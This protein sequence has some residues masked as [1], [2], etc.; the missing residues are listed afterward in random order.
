MASSAPAGRGTAGGHSPAAA[1]CAAGAAVP[2]PPPPGCRSPAPGRLTAV[3]LSATP[4]LLVCRMCCRCCWPRP[5][6]QPLPRLVARTAPDA[7][8]P[9][10]PRLAQHA[11]RHQRGRPVAAAP[12]GAAAVAPPA[13]ARVLAGRVQGAALRRARLMPALGQC[14]CSEARPLAR[15]AGALA[16]QRSM[17]AGVAAAPAPAQRVL[18]VQVLNSIARRADGPQIEQPPPFHPNQTERS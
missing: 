11:R 10:P 1:R 7:P 16:G 18:P 13:V 2:L 9:P 14:H 12:A 5:G 15:W 6:W 4:P 3:H 8:V 17:S